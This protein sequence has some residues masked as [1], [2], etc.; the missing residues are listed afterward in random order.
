MQGYPQL[1]VASPTFEPVFM[2]ALVNELTPAKLILIE[3]EPPSTHNGWRR[4]AVRDLNVGAFRIADLNV[5]TIPT[6]SIDEATHALCE[7]YL[8]HRYSHRL[9]VA[10]AASKLN[11]IGLGIALSHNVEAECVYP[12]P[13]G[14]SDPY[15]DGIGST[16]VFAMLPDSDG[17]DLVGSA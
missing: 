5:I 17:P 3:G 4:Q 14:F 2:R 7:I 13:L 6:N 1:L 9:V 16:S 15:S 8:Q 12:T 11:S 10:P